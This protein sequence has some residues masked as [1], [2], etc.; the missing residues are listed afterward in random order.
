MKKKFLDT[1][2]LLH[3]NN[4]E[5]I[6][7]FIISSKTIEELENIKTSS[8]K[9]DEIKFQARKVTRW[10][11][12]HKDKY[13]IIIV[14]N[15]CH[16]EITSKNLEITNDNLIIASA[17]L[18]N[19]N[20]E[21]IDFYSE[22]ILCGFIAETYFGLNVYRFND[23]KTDK[24]YKGYKVID[25]IS[26]DDLTV[27]YS[28][29]NT[30]NILNCL[31]NEYVVLKQDNQVVD[32]VKWTGNKYISITFK[33]FKS[34][35]FGTVKPL[36]EIQKCAF[37]SISNNDITV[38]YG[39]AGSGKTTIPMAYIWQGLEN[40]KISKCHIIYHFEPLKGSKTLGFEKGSH[41]DK[42]LNY[43]SI[44]NILASKI[45]DRGILESMIGAG[46]IDIIPTANIRGVE[47]SENDV[48][49]ITEGQNLDTYTLKTIIQRCK[50]GCKV[51][52]EG[53]WLEQSDINRT[54]GITRLIE[55]FKGYKSFGCVK[56]KNNYRSEIAELA[57]L[58]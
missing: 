24:I 4:L 3:C 31:V 9:D 45:G 47:Y 17:Y 33:N 27:I 13:K 49:Y 34:R 41:I 19:A 23:E 20:F 50:Q 35:M 39:R 12:D 26:D 37:D 6:S 11:K 38:L 8:K 15:D 52:I 56:L 22:D 14:T 53:D 7:P 32:I 30:E 16:N 2:S 18:Y 10:L 29:D 5:S 46:I 51:I 58:L 25:N 55:V 54:N 1:C 43:G 40:Q 57:D 48:V 21:Q 28:K 42:L 36:D 44:G